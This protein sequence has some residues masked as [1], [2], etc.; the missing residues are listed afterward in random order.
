MDSI[1]FYNTANSCTMKNTKTRSNGSISILLAALLV[2]SVSACKNQKSS[3]ESTTTGPATEET[4]ESKADVI[5]EISEYPL[6]TSFDVTKLLVEAGASYILNL[7]NP[8]DNVDRYISLK[9][10]ALNLGV[11]GADLSYAATYNQTQE[12]MH[13]LNV[14]SDL[15]D[16]LEINGSFNDDMVNRIENNLDNVD[17]LIIII[18]DSFYNTYK[19]LVSNEQD[20]MSL[21]VM[22]GSW[23]EAMYIT[24]QISIISK[25]NSEII[26]I[27]IAQNTSLEKLMEVLDPIRVIDTGADIHEGLSGLQEIFKSAGSEFT[28]KQLEELIKKTEELRNMI[29]T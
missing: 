2:L 21:L 29:I 27:I 1:K 10:K 7:C 12:T 3:N 13:Y 8:V 22:A 5:Q 25:D 28:T 4:Y 6:P 18:S 16:E 23:I 19:Y 17:S 26:D 15:I 11:Y 14:S 9:S 24:T 20:D